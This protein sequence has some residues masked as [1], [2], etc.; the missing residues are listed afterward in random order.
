MKASEYALAQSPLLTLPRELRDEI[1]A[2]LL[3]HGTVPF[4]CGIT[5]IPN[6]REVEDDEIERSPVTEQQAL[7]EYPLRCPCTGRRSWTVPLRDVT[8]SDRVFLPSDGRREE[9]HMTYADG[10]SVGLTYQLLGTSEC[11]DLGIML[12]CKQLYQEAS[13]M[14]YGRNIFSFKADFRMPTALSFLQ[15]SFRTTFGEPLLI[16]LRDWVGPSACSSLAY[17]LSRTSIP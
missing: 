8:G 11:I 9:S 3:L 14:F 6:F 12:V 1:L 7:Q 16:E 17:Q 2:N 5:S 13:E 4:E 10:I 15:V